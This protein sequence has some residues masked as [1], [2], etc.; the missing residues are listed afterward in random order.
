MSSSAH[1]PSQ[2]SRVEVATPLLTDSAPAGH[3][4][5]EG[6]TG[7]WRGLYVVDGQPRAFDEMLG[8]RG[9][10]W[11]AHTRFLAA[12]AQSMRRHF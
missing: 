6:P 5:G 9:V 10:R 3:S 12:F 7:S 2:F 11:H 4:A 8:L 1:A